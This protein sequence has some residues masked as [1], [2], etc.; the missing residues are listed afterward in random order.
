M[1]DTPE[2]IQNSQSKHEEWENASL[3]VALKDVFHLSMI[4]W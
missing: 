4:K 3:G 2:N 1:R